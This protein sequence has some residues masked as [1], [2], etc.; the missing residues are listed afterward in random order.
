MK[1]PMAI[2][3]LFCMCF[4]G[5]GQEEPKQAILEADDSWGKEVI[6]FPVDWAPDVKLKGFEELRFHP[7]WKKVNDSGFWSLVMAWQIDVAQP[8]TVREIEGNFEGYFKGLM[9]PNHWAETFPDPMLVF[10]KETGPNTNRFVGKMGFF[11]GFHT[12]KVMTINIQGEQLFC[13]HSHKA[14]VVFRISP[15]SFENTIWKALH[16]VVPAPMPCVK[17][18]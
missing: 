12:G 13:E 11:D 5:L 18:E 2:V 8:L 6:P 14:T 9:K 7:Q 3:F 15:Q 17:L 16:K 1:K 10:V 4:V